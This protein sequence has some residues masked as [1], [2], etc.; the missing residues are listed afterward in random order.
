MNIN[1]IPV[2]ADMADEICAIIKAELAPR[3]DKLKKAHGEELG[4]L[5]LAHELNSRL[6][7]AAKAVEAGLGFAAEADG[8]PVGFVS[9]AD[10]GG[11]DTI[12]NITCLVGKSDEIKSL[13]QSFA[14][15]KLREKGK[16]IARMHAFLDGFAGCFT[17]GLPE[18]T[19][20]MEL[21]NREHGGKV[22]N[23]VTIVP[24]VKEHADAARNIFIEGWK[25]IRK[26]QRSLIGD[27]A[28]YAMFTNW[29]P[30]KAKSIDA[31]AFGRRTDRCCFSAISDGRVAGALTAHFAD[32][33][34]P[35]ME[36]GNNSVSAEFA[37]QGIGSSL[38]RYILEEGKK[39]GYK[40]AK[41]GT[42]LDEGHAP[43]RRAY[44][45]AGFTRDIAIETIDYYMSI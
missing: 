43:A 10:F 37:G 24:T 27:E 23:D 45:K 44:E 32:G 28:Y 1:I 35:V 12:G 2:S 17:R 39:R 9:V 13:L 18:V 7:A 29:E 22:N 16:K 8:E 5:M 6:D 19:Y 34:I 42:G 26:V 41:V 11:R 38:Y 15:D 20:Y 21:A 4:T 3:L 33:E 31:C 25:P 30:N 40:Y 36:I 14:V